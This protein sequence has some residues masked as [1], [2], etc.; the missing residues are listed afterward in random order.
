MTQVINI[1]IINDGSSDSSLSIILEYQ[2]KYPEILLI[3]QP[4]QGAA[5]ARNKRIT[6]ATGEFISFIDADDFLIGDISYIFSE[7][8]ALI[9]HYSL[10]IKHYLKQ[11]KENSGYQDVVRH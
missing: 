1:F 6:L 5:V 7:K 10:G 4:N 11:K 9:Q 2:Q 8:I 3:K